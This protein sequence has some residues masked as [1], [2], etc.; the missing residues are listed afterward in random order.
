METAVFYRFWFGEI[1]NSIQNF[2]QC[3]LGLK[4]N[5][6]DFI[7]Y[8][9]LSKNNITSTNNLEHWK[10]IHFGNIEAC[11]FFNIYLHILLVEFHI[12]M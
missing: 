12:F 11:T 10:S 7:S 6:L 8:L 2:N 5:E 3:E 4:I 9:R 1:L